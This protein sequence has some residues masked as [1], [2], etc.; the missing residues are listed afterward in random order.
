MAGNAPTDMSLCQRS[1]RTSQG[2]DAAIEMGVVQALVPHPVVDEPVVQGVAV[3]IVPDDA[4]AVGAGRPGAPPPGYAR[5]YQ[6]WP[7]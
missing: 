4:V 1:V 6:A 5:V 3:L 2:E 7:S